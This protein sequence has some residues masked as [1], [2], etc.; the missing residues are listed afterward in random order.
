[1]GHIEVIDTGVGIAQEDTERIF[2][3]FERLR[4]G[5]VEGTGLGLTVTQLLVGLLGGEIQVHSEPGR[6]SRFQLSVYLPVVSRPVDDKLEQV[7]SSDYVGPRRSVLIV[8]DEAAHRNVLAQL[9]SSLGFEVSQAESGAQCLA[10]LDRAPADLVLLDVNLP[11]ERGWSVCRRI[12]ERPG[13]RIG[14]LMVSGS[15]GE[16]NEAD[17]LSAGADGFVPK[18]VIQSELLNAIRQCLNLRWEGVATEPPAERT[19]AA[20]PSA[21]VVRELLALAAGGY[22]KALRARLAELSQESAAS[23]AWVA[24][25]APLVESDAPGLKALLVE[26]LRDARHE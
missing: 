26:T 12:R 14:V 21:Q 19:D 7:Q 24:H 9:L 6:G 4:P 16:H 8:D 17:R 23:A 11:D 20:P 1:M 18:P 2:R 10:E 15:V 25:L 5:G 22:P 13:P 3:P